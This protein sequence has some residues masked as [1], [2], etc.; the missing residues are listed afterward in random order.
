[1]ILIAKFARAW[2]M[3]TGECVQKFEGHEARV[4]GIDCIGTT[5]L[6]SSDDGT[7]R[8][9]TL[10]TGDCLQVLKGIRFMLPFVEAV[11]G[12]TDGPQVTRVMCTE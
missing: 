2:N 3:K 5:V 8:V 4:N 9:W 1:V 6:S 12:L 7:V 11:C 10:D